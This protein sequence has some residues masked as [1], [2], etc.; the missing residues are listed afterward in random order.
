MSSY[1]GSLHNLALDNHLL[2]L[3]INGIKNAKRADYLI[4]HVFPGLSSSNYV[5]D[6]SKAMRQSNNTNLVFQLYDDTTMN[7][8][9]DNLLNEYLTKL[10]NPNYPNLPDPSNY[11]Y[12]KYTLS[13]LKK[14][15]ILVHL[16]PMTKRPEVVAVGE[17]EAFTYLGISPPQNKLQLCCASLCN[18]IKN[19][20]CC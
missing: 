12:P 4:N 14:L 16:N 9:Y 3:N 20:C 7:H 18:F 17:D 15:P 5:Y 19:L 1:N 13:E 10:S 11:N 8:E 6:E 2:F